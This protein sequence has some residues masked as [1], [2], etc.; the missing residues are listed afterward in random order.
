R[1]GTKS[2]LHGACAA[3]GRRRHRHGQPEHPRDVWRHRSSRWR[4]L[5]ADV[6][7]R[8]QN[9][10]RGSEELSESFPYKRVVVTGGAGFL[11][12]NIVER[13]RTQSELEIFAPRSAD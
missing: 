6:I 1:M 2:Y 5:R 4:S 13:L 10:K 12:R 3:D 7:P 8:K 11:G 9:L